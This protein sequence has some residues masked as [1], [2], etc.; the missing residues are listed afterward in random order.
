MNNTIKKIINQYKKQEI[1]LFCNNKKIPH[2]KFFL[3]VWQYE[4]PKYIIFQY[5]L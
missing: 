2:Y 4:L 5:I 1:N 3:I